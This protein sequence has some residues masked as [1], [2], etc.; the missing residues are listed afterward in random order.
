MLS[1]YVWV[2]FRSLEWS[3]KQQ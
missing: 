1:E 2:S 3:W